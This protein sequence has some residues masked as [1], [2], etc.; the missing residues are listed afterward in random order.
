MSRSSCRR[1][2]RH[3]L[4][5]PLTL[6]RHTAPPPTPK[7]QSP[8][9]PL[10][11]PSANACWVRQ[12]EAPGGSH[13]GSTPCAATLQPCPKGA[14]SDSAPRARPH[15]CVV[16]PTTTITAYPLS[17]TPHHKDSLPETYPVIS[18]PCSEKRDPTRSSAPPSSV[19]S[20]VVNSILGLSMPNFLDSWDH[21]FVYKFFR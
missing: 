14:G 11:Q 9:P 1:Q 21:V 5:S 4:S 19:V 20:W 13:Q 16:P 10:A 12:S 6:P 17:L 15:G 2:T 7:P 3:P 18:S 8:P